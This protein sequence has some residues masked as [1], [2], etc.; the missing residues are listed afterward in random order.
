M[1]R[2][3]KGFRVEAS[4]DGQRFW[5]PYRQLLVEEEGLL[6][7]AWPIAGSPILFPKDR[8]RFLA[9]GQVLQMP[10]VSAF[11]KDGILIAS[12]RPRGNWENLFSVLQESGYKFVEYPPVLPDLL[13]P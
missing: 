9:V 1:G 7:R 12:F 13:S 3:N 8:I 10:Y 2:G 6:V 5:W 11:G 4:V